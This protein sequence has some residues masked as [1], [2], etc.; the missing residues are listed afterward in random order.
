MVSTS[1]VIRSPN[2]LLQLTYFPMKD[3]YCNSDDGCLLQLN[4]SEILI[5]TNDGYTSGY[6]MC[7]ALPV[8]KHSPIFFCKGQL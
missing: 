2:M 1:V 8:V 4:A 3:V 6:S 5:A 7:F